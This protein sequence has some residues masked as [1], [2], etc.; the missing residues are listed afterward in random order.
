MT[1]GRLKRVSQYVDGE[2]FCFTYGDGVGNVDITALI[3]YH[4]E[5]GT[6]AT[7]TG[8]QPPERYGTMQIEGR[9]V[10]DFREKPM[11]SGRWINGGFF[12]L[13][14]SVFGR[15]AGNDTTW[16]REPLESLVREG[17]LSVYKHKGFWRPMD[18]LRDKMQLEELWARNQAPWKSW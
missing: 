1:G 8:V 11:N 3:D 4:R 9:K 15:I 7:I 10:T 16:E 17:E 18:T 6:Q 2:T 13:E 5:Q 14:P 12:V